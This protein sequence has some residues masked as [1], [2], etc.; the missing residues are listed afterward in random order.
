MSVREG[1]ERPKNRFRGA[2]FFFPPGPAVIVAI[3]VAVFSRFIM[4]L[5]GP[6]F[7]VASNAVILICISAIFLAISTP[8]NLAMWSLD[9][10]VPAIALSL[11]RGGVLVIAAYALVG[12]GA[13]GLVWANVIMAVCASSA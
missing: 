5:Y 4:G 2:I 10:A 6:A 1:E 3:L 12:K 13:E 11:V 7:Q 9:A 8:M